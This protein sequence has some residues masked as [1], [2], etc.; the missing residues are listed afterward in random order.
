[1]FHSVR[2][3]R[4]ARAGG[5]H[6][7]SIALLLCL[8]ALGAAALTPPLSAQDSKDKAIEQLMKELAAERAAREALEKRVEQLEG[9]AAPSGDDLER[10]L[11]GLVAP[12]DLQKAPPRPPSSPAFYDPAI[13]VFMDS[14]ADAGNFDQRLGEDTDNFRLREAEV[15][16]RLPL[17]PFAE[18]VAIFSWENEGNNNFNATVEEGYANINVGALTDTNVDTTAKLGR[19]RPIFGRN[20]QLHLHDWLQVYQPLPVRNLLGPEGLVGEGVMVHQPITDWE[21]AGGL[22]RTVNLDFSVVNGEMFIGDTALGE[23]ADEAGLGLQSD[24]PMYVARLSQYSELDALSD[25]ELG[26]SAIG[27]L[28]A[29]AVTTDAGERV[30]VHYLDADITWR[31]RAAEHGVGSWLVQAEGMR[32]WIDDTSSDFVPDSS[33]QG[34]WLT[35]QR[36]TSANWYVGVLYGTSDVLS[37]TAHQDSI[38]PYVTWYADEFFRVR[39]EFEHLTQNGG[40]SDDNISD[41][42]R[43]LLQFTWNFGVHAPHPYW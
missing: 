12:G 42:N 13:G 24:D 28:G 21:G 9:K 33:D 4:T 3:P 23:A 5:A 26:V 43:L 40:G 10:Q 15:D 11:Q 31:D 30:H 8:A 29:N 7:P 25:L 6:P 32:A 22:G 41:A 27:P 36:Q 39:G 2:G 17:S 19:F 18:G 1:V 35:V 37:S 34:W 16:M 14:V 38:A 20:N